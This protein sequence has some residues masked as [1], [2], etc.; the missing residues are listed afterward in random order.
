MDKQAWLNEIMKEKSSRHCINK[1]EFNL[2]KP[3]L[4]TKTNNQANS[5]FTHIKEMYK[6]RRYSNQDE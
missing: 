4:Q 6:Y 1:N 3:G 2:R 5:I